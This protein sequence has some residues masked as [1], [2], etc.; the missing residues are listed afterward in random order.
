MMTW[1][2]LIEFYYF[3]WKFYV[4]VLCEVFVEG[5]L[6]AGLVLPDDLSA[7]LCHFSFIVINIMK[8]II[9]GAEREEKKQRIKYENR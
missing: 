5:V 7:M 9:I 3:P 4:F 6:S 1:S 8:I 2:Y